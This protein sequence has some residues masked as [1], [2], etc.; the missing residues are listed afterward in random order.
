[1]KIHFKPPNTIYCVYNLTNIPY[2]VI[3]NVKPWHL[4]SSRRI[5]KLW[6]I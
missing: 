2:I 1:M 5:T 6:C 4:F 3:I